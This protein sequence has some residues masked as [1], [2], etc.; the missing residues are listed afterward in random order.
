VIAVRV[1]RRKTG[2]RRRADWEL[3]ACGGAVHASG[4]LA[5]GTANKAQGVAY[6]A[7]AAI[8]SWQHMQSF[9]REIFGESG[10]KIAAV[11]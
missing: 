8:R 5:A 11:Q 3:I 6:Q 7:K 2:S 10:Q 9:F 1:C 4:K